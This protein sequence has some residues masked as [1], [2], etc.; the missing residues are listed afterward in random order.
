LKPSHTRILAVL[1][2]LLLAPGI[3]SAQDNNPPNPVIETLLTQKG[4]TIEGTPILAEEIIYETYKQNGF[5]PIWTREKLEEMMQLIRGAQAHGLDPADYEPDKLFTLFTQLLQNPDDA[6]RARVEILLTESLLRYGAHRR[7]G[8]VEAR[9]IDPDIN[10]RRGTFGNRPVSQ[11]INDAL[12]SSSLAAFIDMAAPTGPYYH[13]MQD[14]LARYRE[15]RERGGYSA[16]PPGPTLREGD[17]SPRVEAIRARLRASGDLQSAGNSQEYDSELKNAVIAFQER[18]L[19]D[20]DGIVGKQSIEAMN[21]P[22]EH[23]ID[24]IRLTLERLRWVLQE[25]A[26][27]VVVVNIAQ[28]RTNFFKD[29]ELA[30]S[31]RAMVGKNYRKT[32]VFRGDIAYMEFNPTWTIPPGILR[33]DTLPA[34]KKNPNYLAEKNIE[35]IDNKGRVIDPSTVNWS[36]Y[37]R[38]VPY[39]LRQTPG[40]HNALGTVKFIFP[41]EHFVFLHDTPHRELFDRP[42]RAFSSGCIRVEDPLKLAELLLDNPAKYNRSTLQSVIDSRETQRIHLK[43]KIPVVIVYLTAGLGEEGEIVFMHDVYNRDQR[44]LDAL[45]GPVHIR[46]PGDHAAP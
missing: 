32:P 29:G 24:Q 30:W 10:F 14:W 11:N 5:R 2:A 38:S 19:L 39:T 36:Q 31:T 46:L 15:I 1:A 41:N 20:A 37:S 34:I 45:N 23:R 35:V 26:D 43:P 22:V 27:T 21:V 7:Y 44:V 17:S 18:H 42:E 9:K 25:R 3:L 40:P 6:S 12:S 13:H 16:V 33:N 28:Y 8:K 4:L